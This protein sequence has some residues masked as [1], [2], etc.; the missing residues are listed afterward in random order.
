MSLEH[1]LLGLLRQPASGYALKTIF[2]ERINCFWTAELSQIYPTLQ[3]LE[4]RGLLRSRREKAKRGP[5]QRVYHVTSAGRRVLRAWLESDLE[6]G[7][8]RIPYLAKLCSMDELGDARKTLQYLLRLRET[9]ARRHAALQEIERC[10]CED[11]PSFPDSLSP[12][13]FHVLLTLRN[14]L[15]MLEARV[16]WCDE[17]IRRVKARMEKEGSHVRNVS[18]LALGAH[19]RGKHRAAAV[20][21]SSG[22]AK[23]RPRTR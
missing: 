15:C 20:L 5:G 11:D 13:M 19:N 1:I 8:D 6:M 17:S 23:G 22:G 14:G 16:K 4:R 3:R 7:D 21:D 18:R 12:Q 10:W 2:D 9:F